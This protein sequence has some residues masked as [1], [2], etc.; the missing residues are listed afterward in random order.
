MDFGCAARRDSVCVCDTVCA[1]AG[2]RDQV[3]PKR[4]CRIRA[5]AW[6]LRS[7]WAR[8]PRAAHRRCECFAFGVHTR[9]VHYFRAGVGSQFAVS[10][11][12]TDFYYGVGGA[13]CVCDV[14][15]GGGGAPSCH[16]RRAVMSRAARRHGARG[17]PSCH[18]RRRVTR[19][20]GCAKVLVHMVP[21]RAERPWRAWEG[22]WRGGAGRGS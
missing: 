18:A 21:T 9:S 4:R 3:V 16:A 22:G 17:A 11:L 15:R 1:H 5:H 13:L 19:A 12:D 8:T 20:R 10:P 6:P 2:R 7:S 14:T